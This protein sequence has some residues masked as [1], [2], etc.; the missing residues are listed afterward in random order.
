MPL[1]KEQQD[2]AIKTANAKA[3]KLRCVACGQNDWNLLGHLV[4]LPVGP[5]TLPAG[6]SPCIMV[7]CKVCGNTLFFNVHVLGI[8]KELGVPPPGVPIG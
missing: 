7:T 6:F 5:P 8:A 3:K 4:Y 2:L 1:T